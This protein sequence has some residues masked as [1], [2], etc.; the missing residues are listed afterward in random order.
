[1][2]SIETLVG[3]IAN[4]IQI[5]TFLFTLWVLW[6]AR[7]RLQ[8]AL[9]NIQQSG[10]GIKPV[11]IAIGINGGIEGAVNQYLTTIAQPMQVVPINRDG[12]IRGR[13][14]Y[15]LLRELHELKVK[16]TEQGVTEV[17]L[18]YKGPVTIAMG[19]GAI[20]DNWVPVKVYELD[21]QTGLYNPD[22][23]LGKGAVLDLLEEIIREGEEAVLEK[24]VEG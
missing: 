8:I 2:P 12:F 21:K 17:H 16:L 3:W 9:K 5:I 6:R 23:V 15:D 10:N 4:L 14:S 24:V 19:V 7:R 22:L 20:L 13:K 11:A 1:M 18:F